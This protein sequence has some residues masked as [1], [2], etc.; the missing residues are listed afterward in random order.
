MIYVDLYRFL[1]RFTLISIDF[2]RICMELCGFYMESYSLCMDLHGF[3]LGYH[4][5]LEPRD[6]ESFSEA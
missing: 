3:T 4:I 6:F 2:I 1:Y 5:I